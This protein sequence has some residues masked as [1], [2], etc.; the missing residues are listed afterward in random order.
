MKER[1]KFLLEWEKRWDAGKGFVNVSELCREFGVSRDAGHRLIARYK[2][3]GHDV[4]VAKRRSTRPRTMPTKTAQDVEELI[5]S[6]RKAHPTW[7]PKKL[8]QW[9]RDRYDVALPSPSTIGD[10]LKRRGLTLPRRRRPR[11][12]WS[13]QPFA[14]VDAPNT[15]WC[16]DFKG[17]F[18]MLDGRVCYPLTIVDAHTRFLIRC[19]ALLDPNGAEVMRVFD[20]AFQEF[21]LPRAIRSDNGPPFVTVGVGGLSDLTVWWLRLGIRRERIQ[22]GKPQQNGR[23]ERF[24]RTLKAEVP[25][26]RGLV[27]QQRAFD[28]FRKEYNDERPH[29]ALKMKTPES[30][31][32]RS[33]RRYP[34]PMKRFEPAP[35]NLALRVDDRGCIRWEGKRVFVSSSLARLD[36][37]LC[38]LTE[39][40][41]D[42]GSDGTLSFGP[43]LLGQLRGGELVDVSERRKKK[44][45]EEKVSGMSSD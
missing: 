6:A 32:R 25:P 5:V 19:E 44:F 12:K 17:H 14:H 37:E 42:D 1:V 34:R 30:I 11:S 29:E 31:F 24:H 20:S 28:A 45:M 16:V 39:T 9:L 18:R 22:P 13:S 3:A 2:A 10:V 27:E 36:V 26:Q 8:R 7:G 21:G 35:W 15:T 33:S 40:G 38:R 43:V 23:Q 41:E 4:D